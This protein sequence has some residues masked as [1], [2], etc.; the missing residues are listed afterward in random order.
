MR[1]AGRQVHSSEVEEGPAKAKRW[2]RGALAAASGASYYALGFAITTCN[3][4]RSAKSKDGTI[5]PQRAESGRRAAV[6]GD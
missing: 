3:K 1:I 6:R 2:P 5:R 4:A